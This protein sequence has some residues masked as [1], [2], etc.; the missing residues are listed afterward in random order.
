M[1]RFGAGGKL[2]RQLTLLETAALPDFVTTLFSEQFRVSHGTL[3]EATQINPDALLCSIAEARLDARAIEMLPKSVR[4]ILTYSVG[5]DH[6]DLNAAR[7]RKIAVFNTPGV[8]GD[9]VADAAMLLTLGAARRATE[10]I[11]LIRSGR[12]TGWT[13]RQLI[14][15]GL[16]G[17]TL[18][19]LGMGD[20]G[21][22]VAHRA[23]A[24][25]MQI[26]YHNRRP[27]D[28]HDANWLLARELIATSDVILLAWP[29]TPETRYFINSDTLALVKRTAI[30]VNVGR[31]DLVQDEG[32]VA[33]LSN[34]RIAAAGLDVFDREPDFDKRYLDLPNAFLLPHIGSSTYEARLGMGQVLIDALLSWTSGG[35]PQNRVA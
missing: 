26:V 17:K 18:G 1:G 24:F 31:G 23:R 10:S 32:L 4:A 7:A 19:I 5:L 9:A 35:T 14:G 6:I 15:V 16:S 22:R 13:P 28:E 33:A 21:K 20:I 11:D 8:L 27:V 29:S 2:T 12:W 30:L 3:A 25:G 34:G